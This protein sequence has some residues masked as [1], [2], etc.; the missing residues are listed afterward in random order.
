MKATELVTIVPSTTLHEVKLDDLIG[1][2]GKI[3]ELIYGK[4]GTIGGA[5][6]LLSGEP[7]LGES[8]WFI[9]IN[10]LIQ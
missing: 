4:D 2:Q 6:V 8:E 7:Y 5:W 9:P 10:S 1:R 3:V